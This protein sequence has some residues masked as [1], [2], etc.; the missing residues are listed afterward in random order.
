VGDCTADRRRAQPSSVPIPTRVAY[1]QFSYDADLFESLKSA[2]S[3][4]ITLNKRSRI[5]VVYRDKDQARVKGRF[6]FGRRK[7][8]PW[9][10][11]GANVPQDGADTDEQAS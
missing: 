3:D 6:I 9:E 2:I 4:A 1:F 5:Y 11:F 10:G 7:G 8:A